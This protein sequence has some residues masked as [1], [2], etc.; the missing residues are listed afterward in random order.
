MPDIRPKVCRARRRG[1]HA[2]SAALKRVLG[3][4][5]AEIRPGRKRLRDHLS[6]LDGDMRYAWTPAGTAATGLTLRHRCRPCVPA[7]IDETP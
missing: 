4:E 5:R 3:K 2:Y 1:Y 6:L 7:P